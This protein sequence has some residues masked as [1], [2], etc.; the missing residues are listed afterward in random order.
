[1]NHKRLLVLGTMLLVGI[2]LAAVQPGF[3]PK[4]IVR[5]CWLGHST[6]RSPASD[7]GPLT[8]GLDDGEFLIDTSGTQAEYRPAI[9]FDGANFLVTWED[10]RS[11]SYSDIYAARV[12][13]QGTVLDPN[14]IPVSTATNSQ[15][16]PAIAFD[17][18][19]FLVTWYDY[20]SGSSSDIYAARVTPQGTVLDPSGVPIS[21]AA[22]NQWSPAL[23]FDGANFL[24]TWDDYRSG[25]DYDIYAARVT[26]QGT[27]L[28]PSGIPVSTATSYEYLPAV[29][30]DGANFLVTWEDGRSGSSYDIYAA[31]VTPQGTVLDPNGI[32]VSTVAD[33]QWYPALAFDGANFLVTWQDNRSDPS[34]DIYAARVT[35]QGT[36]LD[37]NGIPISTATNDQWY[38]AVAF[39]GANFLVTWTDYRSGTSYDIYAARV[40][41]GG[42]VF[43]IG[44][45]VRQEGNQT[46]PALARG[47]GNQMFLVYQGW[48][49]TVNGKTY[50]SQRIWGK[51]G[52]FPGVQETTNDEVRRTNRLPTIVRGVLFV[53]REPSAVS[54]KPLSLLD[55]SGRKVL[56]LQP[57][58]ND[59]S[60]LAPG[61]YFVRSWPSAVSREPSAVH[62]VVVQH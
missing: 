7:P 23:A 16:L 62:K 35:P 11:V 45:A 31:R 30:F 18:A 51:F 8:P 21:T 27:V 32:P 52:P 34:Y 42:V 9:A 19:N 29:A 50:N 22:Y 2:G 56:D 1:M 54:R 12:T 28:D 20:R 3:D 40:T 57:G 36:V 10:Y 60:R 37:P 24:V 25:S 55:I 61:V 33:Y 47:P 46:Y 53:S 26:P 4:D 48:A 39:D 59:V 6:T 5:Q 58:P 44:P 49:G 13:P 41:P 14:G 38:P 15:Y 17:G 43:D